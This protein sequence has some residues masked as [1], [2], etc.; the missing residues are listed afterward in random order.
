MHTPSLRCVLA[1]AIAILSPAIPSSG[2]TTPAQPK[3][4]VLANRVPGQPAMALSS[5]DGTLTAVWTAQTPDA[6]PAIRYVNSHGQHCE[7]AV[8][9]DHLV[10]RRDRL[11]WLH[12]NVNHDGRRDFRDAILL[13]DGSGGWRVLSVPSVCLIVKNPR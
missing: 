10:Q 7:L 11:G 1:A 13:P 9:G 5:P 4:L 12:G 8:Y 3:A 2:Q 6:L